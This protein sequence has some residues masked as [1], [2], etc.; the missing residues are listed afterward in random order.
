MEMFKMY[1]PVGGY[2][3]QGVAFCLKILICGA[4]L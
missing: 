2:L 1:G 4:A 3:E